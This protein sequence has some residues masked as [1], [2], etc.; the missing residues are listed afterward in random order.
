MGNCRRVGLAAGQ[1]QCWRQLGKVWRRRLG[2]W[3]RRRYGIRLGLGKWP[4]LVEPA[5]SNG[6]VYLR[7]LLRVCYRLVA[8]KD[9]QNRVSAIL[10]LPFNA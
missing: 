4:Q 10:L 3:R 1:V 8:N 2:R 9:R 7:A 5:K 6:E